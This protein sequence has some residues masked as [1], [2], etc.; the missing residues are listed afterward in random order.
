MQQRG[1]PRSGRGDDG[2]LLGELVCQLG[3][4]DDVDRLVS[5]VLPHD[6]ASALSRGEWNAPWSSFP[7]APSCSVRRSRRRGGTSSRFRQLWSLRCVGPE[8]PTDGAPDVLIFT[9]SKREK[10]RCSSFTPYWTPSR[11]GSWRA[12]STV[13][14]P[15]VNR[16][17]LGGR[18]RRNAARPDGTHG[19]VVVTRR[20][21]LHAHAPGPRKR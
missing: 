15:V 2:D 9:S 10:L 8:E 19:P 17:H 4:V 1:W 14:R 13:P 5:V 3:P 7:A 16:K 11:R 21:D 20:V 18:D 6:V 12:G